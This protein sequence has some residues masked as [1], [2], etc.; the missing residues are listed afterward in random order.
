MR[1]MELYEG[2]SFVMIANSDKPRNLKIAFVIGLQVP[3]QGAA[4]RRIEFFARYLSLKKFNVYV[5]SPRTLY[6]A[7]SEFAKDRKSESRGRT[8][9]KLITV[10]LML[11]VCKSRLLTSILEVVSSLF[12]GILLLLIKPKIIVLSIPPHQYLIG[13]Y[14]ASRLS[15][16][17]L[18][19]DLRDPIDISYVKHYARYQ[20][21]K[22]LMRIARTIE[23]SALYKASA[24]LYVSEVMAKDLSRTMPPLSMKMHLVPNGADLTVYRPLGKTKMGKPGVFKLFFMGRFLEHINFSVILKALSI[25]KSKHLNVKL[26][27]AGTLDPV[28]YD[29]AKKLGVQDSIV[30]LGLLSANELVTVMNEMDLAVLP[31]YNDKNYRCSLPAK[32]YEY[33]ACGLPILVSAPLYFE[34]ARIVRDHGI[35]IWCPAEDVSCIVNAIMQL[36]K[37]RNK[38]MA[39]AEKCLSFR[40]GIDR[41]H[42]AEKLISIINGFTD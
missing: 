28:L 31:Y 29:E 26:Y 4:W 17:K 20:A 2:D 21:L 35:G 8:L 40:S 18:I 33:I 34:V 15:R 22:T 3:F 10:P 1:Y 41:M 30:Y 13:T 25:L 19:V 37:D 36:Y 9:F 32:F 16:A 24:I 6:L 27:I 7:C 38:L 11:H 42:S 12:S 23:Y 39:L 5:I 14:L